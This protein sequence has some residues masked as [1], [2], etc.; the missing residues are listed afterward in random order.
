MKKMKERRKTEEEK[1]V[2]SRWR[3]NGRGEVG[4]EM[5]KKKNGRG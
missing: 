2:V 4:E 3:E 5:K 1:R